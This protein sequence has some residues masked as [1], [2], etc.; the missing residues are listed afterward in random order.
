MKF[1]GLFKRFLSTKWRIIVSLVILIALSVTVKVA[2]PLIIRHIID[3]IVLAGTIDT[4]R[5]VFW[6]ISMG[7]IK[8][9][10]FVFDT[11]LIRKKIIIV[12]EL[13]FI[14]SK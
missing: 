13:T 9:F 7:L 11:Q 3:N 2:N 14:F 6:T 8:I 12:N 10:V 4:P 1:G 5:L